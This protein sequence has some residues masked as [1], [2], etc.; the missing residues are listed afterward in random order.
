MKRIIFL[1]AAA[2]AMLLPAVGAQAQSCRDPWV[3]ELVTQE[4][5]RAPHGSGE[6]GECNIKRY[7]NGTWA[8]KDKLREYVRSAGPSPFPTVDLS[9]IK[10]SS[11]GTNA[12]NL[13]SNNGLAIGMLKGGNITISLPANIVAAG[14]GNIVAAGGGNI[15]AAGGGNLTNGIN[16]AMARNPPVSPMGGYSLQGVN[17]LNALKQKSAH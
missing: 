14:G 6:T 2:A 8:N 12:F 16:A 3:T 10:Y 13:Q 7:N 15:V 5:K 4:Y 11:A 1:S 17:D 9:R